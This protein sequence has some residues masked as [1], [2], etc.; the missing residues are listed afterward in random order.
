MDID[1][2]HHRLR[3]LLLN[4]KDSLAKQSEPHGPIYYFSREL[5][6]SNKGLRSFY[7]RPQYRNPSQTY[8]QFM[9][10]LRRNNFSSPQI[11]IIYGTSGEKLIV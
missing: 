5:I 11:Q 2:M 3:E 8:S 4:E 9:S 10:L 7:I 1:K 6:S